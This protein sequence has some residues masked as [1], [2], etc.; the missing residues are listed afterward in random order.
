M[1]FS[2]VGRLGSCSKFAL[3][4]HAEPARKTV[5]VPG[6]DLQHHR[7]LFRAFGSWHPEQKDT[8]LEATGC[9]NEFAKVGVQSKD[10]SLLSM[11]HGE[12]AHIGHLWVKV[13]DKQDFMTCG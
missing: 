1:R 10:N 13:A 4:V 11:R 3:S 12:N 2:V 7:G 8:R 9:M 5:S 6:D